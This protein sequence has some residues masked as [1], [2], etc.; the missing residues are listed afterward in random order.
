[1]DK[2]KLITIALGLIVGIILAAAYFFGSKIFPNLTKQSKLTTPAIKKTPKAKQPKIQTTLTITIPDDNSQTTDKTIKLSGSF[3]PGSTIVLFANADEKIA[4]GDA[5]GK[6][7]FNV[8]LEEGENEIS[9]T[10]F[11]I[12]GKIVSAKRNVTLEVSQ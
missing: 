11:D 4:S 12:N 1:M 6:F 5:S 2:E 7:N 8:N 9:I 3:I 10:S